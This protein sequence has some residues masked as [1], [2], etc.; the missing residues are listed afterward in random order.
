MVPTT[1]AHHSTG[2]RLERGQ[3]APGLLHVRR[4]DAVEDARDAAERGAADGGG[5]DGDALVVRV[6]VVGEAEEVAE[7]DAA[8]ADD[9][10][11]GADAEDAAAGIGAHLV[12]DVV[13]EAEA[14]G[15]E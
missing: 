4:V 3:V 2:A 15:G 14:G 8:E 11:G 10:E 7:G 6:Q 12:E 13:L 1:R 5:E 9:A